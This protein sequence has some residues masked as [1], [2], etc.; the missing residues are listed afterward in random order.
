[1]EQAEGPVRTPCHC[2]GTPHDED[3]FHLVD[4]EHL[5]IDAGIAAASALVTV[6]DGNAGAVLIGAFLRHGAIRSWNLLDEDGKPVP[7]NP[8]TVADRLTWV[9]GGTELASAA[10]SRYINAQ[11]LAPFGLS[12]SERTTADSSSDGQT[13]PSTSPPT[14]S[15]GSPLELSESSSPADSDGVPS[16]VP[17][18]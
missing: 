11:T 1:M 7:V 10:L 16:L 12:T 15:S 2:P 5:P 4:A 8:S 18:P 9:K 13:E 14:S 17:M 6:G 3:V